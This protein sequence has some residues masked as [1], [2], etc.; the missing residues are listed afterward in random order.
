M[1]TSLK[2]I[3]SSEQRFSKI[4]IAACRNSISMMREC[5]KPINVYVI[6]STLAEKSSNLQILSVTIVKKFSVNI[7]HI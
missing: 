5:E 3:N 1:P 4:L 2:P 6:L 7:S